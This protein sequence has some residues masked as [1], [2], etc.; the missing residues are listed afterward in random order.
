[1]ELLIDAAVKLQ[2]FCEKQ[3]WDY[4]FI[5][6]IAVQKWGEPRM[7]R[8]IDISL[9]TGFGNELE[10]IDKLLKYFKPRINDAKEFALNNRVLLLM[11]ESGIGIDISLAALPFEKQV[12]E[13]ATNVNYGTDIFLKI[14][15][16]EDL[17]VYKAFANRSKDWLDVETILLKHE[18]HELDWR[19]INETLNPL[20][21]IKN[22]TTILDRLYQLQKTIK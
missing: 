13:R 14:C 16:A 9:L 4:C 3:S 6:G 5:G 11:T 17:V 19:Y 18:S 2:N 7:T 15:S 20:C 8:D 21:E 12:I 22:D 10:Y 1:M